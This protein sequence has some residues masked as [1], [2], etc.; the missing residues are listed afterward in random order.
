MVRDLALPVRIIAAATQREPDGL[1]MSSRNA[2]LSPEE[3]QIAGRLNMILKDAVARARTGSDLR[4]AEAQAIEALWAASFSH[5]D[6]VAIRD[7][8]TLDHMAALERPARILAAVK[9][10]KTRLIDNMAV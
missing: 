9:V 4:A 1:A 6:Y 3:R 2:Y 10:G 5:V 7:A 8:E